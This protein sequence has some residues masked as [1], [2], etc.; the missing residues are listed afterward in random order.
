MCEL[1]LEETSRSLLAKRREM[2]VMPRRWNKTGHD[3]TGQHLLRAGHEAVFHGSPHM[4]IARFCKT[5]IILSSF[6]VTC[7]VLCSLESKGV[8]SAL[9]SLRASG[10][11]PSVHSH[12]AVVL[13]WE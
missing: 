7:P 3:N 4:T 12:R 5:G 6:K 1:R 10:P 8:S 13:H 2:R 11:D 9:S